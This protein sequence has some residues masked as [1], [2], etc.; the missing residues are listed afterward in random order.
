MQRFYTAIVERSETGFSLYF[1]DLPGCVSAGASI[2]AAAAS[3]GQAMALHLAGLREDG[4]PIPEPTA[5]DKIHADPEVAE[6]A[7]LL[8]PA[9]LSGRSTRLSIT[10]D[11]ALVAAIDAVATNRSGFL[12]DA[13]RAALS[14]QRAA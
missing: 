5:A 13:A 4:D 12:A 9:D 8:V 11:E 2:E 6:V 10:M 7:R 1:P 14:R 3:A